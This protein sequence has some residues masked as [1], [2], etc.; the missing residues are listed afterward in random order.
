M[1]NR[2]ITGKLLTTAAAMFLAAL[3]LATGSAQAATE[4]APELALTCTKSA[5]GSWFGTVDCINNTD[6]TIEFRAV[7]TC[8]TES[9]IGAWVT[10]RPG[11]KGS[12]RAEC[13]IVFDLWWQER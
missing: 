11:E 4:A 13:N 3:P 5:V 2:R 6:R 1:K 10:L 8:Y 9:G 7:A 12:S